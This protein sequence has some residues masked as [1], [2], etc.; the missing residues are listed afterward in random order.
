ML[1]TL[2]VRNFALIESLTVEF[3]PRLNVLSGETGAGKSILVGALGL[4]LG[5]K[6]QVTNIRAGADEAEAR[7]VLRP[8]RSTVADWLPPIAAKSSSSKIFSRSGLAHLVPPLPSASRAR[9][10]AVP[11]AGQYS[12]ETAA[13]ITPERA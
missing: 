13:V 11:V 7:A 3:G 10:G 6:G 1:E 12:A 4:L 8:S 9:M 2:T 5:G